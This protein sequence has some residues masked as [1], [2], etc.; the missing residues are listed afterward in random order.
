MLI[1]LNHKPEWRSSYCEGNLQRQVIHSWTKDDRNWLSHRYLVRSR[2]SNRSGIV[3][4]RQA[5]INDD[6]IWMKLRLSQFSA[7]AKRSPFA[8]ISSGRW[9][10]QSPALRSLVRQP[11]GH[12]PT[13]RPPASLATRIDRYKRPRRLQGFVDVVRYRGWTTEDDRGGMESCCGWRVDAVARMTSIDCRCR[14]W[15]L[16]VEKTFFFSSTSISFSRPVEY[17]ASKR[18]LWLQ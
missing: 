2:E 4:D 11:A 14:L 3:W 16:E 13:D 12:R 9:L 7:I 10:H 6:R 8:N 5:G 18:Q 17:S 1:S 15:L